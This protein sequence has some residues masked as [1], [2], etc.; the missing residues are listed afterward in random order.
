M[1][2]HA[3]LIGSCVAGKV[4][5]RRGNP[6]MGAAIVVGV[7]LCAVI[8]KR[9]ERDVLPNTEIS[10]DRTSRSVD[11][12]RGNLD[13]I[14]Q[15]G[16]R[17]S[18]MINEL[19]DVAKMES[20]SMEY[21]SGSV[22]PGELVHRAVNATAGLFKA[23]GTT[24]AVVEVAPDLPTLTGDSDRLQQ[25]LINLISNAVKFMDEGAVRIEA[26]PIEDGVQFR[27]VDTGPGIPEADYERVFDRFHQTDHGS[28]MRT[29]TG[30]GLPICKHIIEAHGGTIRVD[31]EVG[32]GTTMLVD[33]PLG[34]AVTPRS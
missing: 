3:V 9:L 14:L 28:R 1:G 30:L 6:N 21:E 29:G 25:V 2:F 7:M 10:N 33:L 31:S 34:A 15:E 19:L 13:V 4:L 23:D 12:I 26:R 17:L 11:Q 18:H 8:Q 16:A 22:D 32:R 20:G 24:H 27:V 5:I